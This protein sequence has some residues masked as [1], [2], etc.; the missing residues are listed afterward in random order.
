MQSVHEV[1]IPLNLTNFEAREISCFKKIKRLYTKDDVH[2]YGYAFITF[3]DP[4]HRFMSL[5]IKGLPEAISN[6]KAIPEKYHSD[7]FLWDNLEISKLKSWI[8]FLFSWGIT[9]LILFVN[10]LILWAFG[11]LRFN[12]QHASEYWTE[13]SKNFFHDLGI[14]YTPELWFI[15]IFITL[16]PLIVDV[17]VALTGLILKF[18]TF[19]ENHK[20]KNDQNSSYIAKFVLFYMINVIFPILIIPILNLF[21]NGLDSFTFSYIFGNMSSICDLF[22]L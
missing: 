21:S 1:S 2:R 9:I 17:Y 22:I 11:N 16:T 19:L 15:K 6:F 13:S 20:S 5:G 12:F 8:R 3:K 14:N 10:S 7:E 18:L 4:K